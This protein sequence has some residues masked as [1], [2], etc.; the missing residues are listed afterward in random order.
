[1]TMKSLKKPGIAAAVASIGLLGFVASTP[2]SAGT[3]PLKAQC[4]IGGQ[5]FIT[6][7]VPKGTAYVEYTWL[8]PVLG[9]EPTSN[10][11]PRYA[12]PT[13]AGF[14][15]GGWIYAE[16]K[17]SAGDVLATNNHVVCKY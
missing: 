15:A 1:M 3:L 14:P 7:G 8:D 5:M 11:W 6:G 12:V 16:A 9:G 10:V 17:N 2:A 13:F 4:H